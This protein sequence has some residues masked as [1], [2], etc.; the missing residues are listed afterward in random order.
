MLGFITG[1]WEI[2][3]IAGVIVLLFF[4]RRI[5]EMMRSL[6]KGVTQFKKGLKE[7][8]D[9]SGKDAAEVK[10]L[11]SPQDGDPQK[12]GEGI[13]AGQVEAEQEGAA[14]APSKRRAE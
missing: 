4:G 13:Q 14:D 9:T 12:S 8:D 2:V 1:H 3:V 7:K 6:G 11:P 5:P 10:A